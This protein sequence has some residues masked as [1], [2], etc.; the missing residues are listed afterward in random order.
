[1]MGPMLQSC[2]S[3]IS[4]FVQVEVVPLEPALVHGHVRS[5]QFRRRL[6]VGR[7]GCTYTRWHSTLTM[8]LVHHHE[9]V[10]V[11]VALQVAGPGP[12]GGAKIVELVS[13]G[14][15]PVDSK[16]ADIA[17]EIVYHV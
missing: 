9:L 8:L 4:K 3:G 14:R 5:L 15:S 7:P 10:I 6:A 12:A 1:M 17:A 13:S 16:V 11:G 2:K